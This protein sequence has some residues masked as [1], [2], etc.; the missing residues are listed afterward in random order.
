[1]RATAD[2]DY[3]EIFVCQ[4]GVTQYSRFISGEFEKCR[5]LALGQNSAMRHVS[6]AF[7]S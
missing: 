2:T 3:F 1:V 5:T 6:F 7:L 4:G